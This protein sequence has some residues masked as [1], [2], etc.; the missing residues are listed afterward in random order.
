M[1]IH[2]LSVLDG[3]LAISP[4]PGGGGDFVGDMAHVT[5]WRPAMVITLVTRAEMEAAGAALLGVHV[6]D[7]GSRWLHLPIPDFG[8]PPEEMRRLWPEVSAQ[9]RQ[10]LSGGG[11]VLV[12]CR[13]GCG[14]SGMV[15][16]RL[17]IEAGEAPDEALARLRH[18]RP[19]A[20]ET[21][22]QMGWAMEA[23]RRAALFLRHMD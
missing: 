3:I 11:R 9:A 22:A 23:P 5:E 16:L 1:M 19:C 15:A 6:Q 12:H 21:D 20:V 8:T 14:R 10:A 17:M 13:G 2:A 4:L 18:V 7:H